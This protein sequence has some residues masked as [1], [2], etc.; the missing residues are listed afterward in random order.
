[1]IDN[2]TEP[3]R[4]RFAPSP[5]GHL[6]IGTARTALFNWLFARHYGGRFVLRIEDTDITRSSGEFEMSIAESLSWLGLNWDEGPGIGGDFGPYRQSER[7]STYNDYAGR[8]LKSGHAYNCYCTPEE[9]EADRE[10]A[11]AAGRMPMYV[12][13]CRNLTEDE[14]LAKQ[15]AGLEAVIRFNVKPSEAYQIEF[16]DLV[17]GVISLSSKVIGDFIIIKT[18]KMPTYN[19][20]AAVD[21]VTMDITHVLRGED[22]IT[23]TARQIMVSAALGKA[24]PRFGHFSM[25][26]G[27]DR[28]KLSKR[29]GATS[30]TDYRDRGYLP[31]ALINYLA[32]LSWSSENE[33]EILGIGDLAEKFTIERVSKSPAIFDQPKLDWLNGQWIRRLSGEELGELTRPFMERAGMTV[34]GDRSARISEAIKSNLGALADAP[35]YAKIFVGDLVL[36]PEVRAQLQGDEVRRVLDAALNKIESVTAVDIDCSKEIV[37][38]IVAQLKEE[39]IKGKTVYHPL[40]LALTGED[41][42]PE[43]FLVLN[44]LGKEMAIRRLKKALG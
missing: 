7:R 14:R 29:H 25:I 12:G 39:G 22:H 17:K 32:L 8:L 41:S 11:L 31:E 23:N 5:S 30:I 44:A 6:H 27:P 37:K 19:F 33:E 40:R 3:I 21:D 26:L 36:S 18:D 38:E 9:L 24:P 15:A 4:V 2:P 16:N 28:T 13:R 42:G 20:A 35:K 1:M 34:G 10:T 43:L